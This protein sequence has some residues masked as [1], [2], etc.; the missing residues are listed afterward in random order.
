MSWGTMQVGA[1]LLK[2][3]DILE[4]VT[5]A[6]TGE[7]TVRWE[8]RETAP[9]ATT[10]AAIAA[11]QS[12]IMSF[13]DR[14]FPVQFERKTEYNGF[15]RFTDTNTQFEKWGEGPAQVRWSLAAQYLGPDNAVDLEGRLAN[16][17][18]LNDFS[19]VGER[20]HAPN[21]GHF[22]YDVGAAIPGT[23]VRT[24]EGGVAITVYRA[25]PAGVNPRWASTVA[26]VLSGRARLLSDG[27]ER[28]ATRMPLPA[29]TWELNNGLVKVAWLAAGGGTLRVSTWSGGAWRDKDWGVFYSSSGL[30][31]TWQQCT[32]LR[33][34]MEA[35]AIRL[36][37]VV[38]TGGAILMDLLLRRGSRFVEAYMQ[39]TVAADELKVRLNTLE[40]FT[41][42][43]GYLVATAADANGLKYVVGSSR[44][45]T[46][47]AN[48]GIAKASTRTLDFWLGTV[49]TA[50][51]GDSAATLAQQYIGAMAEKVGVA[52]R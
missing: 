19:L 12:D 22:A 14:V 50:D 37:Q 26:N 38:P 16:V 34:D 33:N 3:T 25:I 36:T 10:Q 27:V 41:A 6:N 5:N 2:E 8:G 51:A 46:N 24:A 4:D 1:L 20:W 18:R 23:V 52:R 13:I 48:G 42:A 49:V 29:T 11:K 21:A 9:S 39:R 47:H 31:P 44:T 7:R 35:V 28:L 30:I 43:T 15:Y 40:A 17:V 45:F 32:V